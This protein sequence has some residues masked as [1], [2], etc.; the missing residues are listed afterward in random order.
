MTI[1]RRL[2]NEVVEVPLEVKD[3]P[4]VEEANDFAEIINNPSD[5]KNQIRYQQL[6]K[7]AEQVNTLLYELRN[8]VGVS[9]SADKE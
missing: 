5:E 1:H 8:Q 6:V 7:L 2:D 3:N 4:M 9:F